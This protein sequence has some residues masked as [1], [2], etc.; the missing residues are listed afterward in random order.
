LGTTVIAGSGVSKAGFTSMFSFVGKPS[1]APFAMIGV[2]ELLAVSV[3]GTDV[4]PGCGSAA[5][6]GFG[7]E[8]SAAG[9]EGTDVGCALIAGARWIKRKGCSLLQPKYPAGAKSNRKM[10]IQINLVPPPVDAEAGWLYE[11]K[12]VARAAA[13]SGNRLSGTIDS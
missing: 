12:I 4:A 9:C 3:A 8:L 13:G 2:P 1:G 6:V 5:G 11:E 10:I 7:D